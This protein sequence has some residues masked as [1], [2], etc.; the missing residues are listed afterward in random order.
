MET[1]CIREGPAQSPGITRGC[2]ASIECLMVC[3]VA[4]SLIRG[5]TFYSKIVFLGTNAL[6]LWVDSDGVSG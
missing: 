1:K 5:E 6:S 4:H 2:V 3:L